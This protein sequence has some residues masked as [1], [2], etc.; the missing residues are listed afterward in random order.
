[1]TEPTIICPKCSNEI[2]LTESLAAPL[3]DAT[4]RQFEQRLSAKDEEIATREQALRERERA[5]VESTRALDQQVAEQVA[6]QLR[7][8][9]ARV[10]AEEAGKA[11]R[12]LAADMEAQARQVAELQE[13]LKSR[14][15]KLADAQRAQA[16]LIKKQRQLDDEKRELDLTVEKRVQGSLV[17]VR[18]KALREAEDGLKQKVMEKIRPSPRCS[19]PSRS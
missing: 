12:Q 18:Q 1:M 7:A 13:V 6:V 19:G 10:S 14:D 5:V 9:R 16:E 3:I 15:L 4:R 2:R 17:E 8:E 11:R